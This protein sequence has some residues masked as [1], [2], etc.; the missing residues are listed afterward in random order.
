M[1][2]AIKAAVKDIADV[3]AQGVFIHVFITTLICWE[4]SANIFKSSMK[5]FIKSLTR[6][7]KVSRL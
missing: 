2:H 6:N 7:R 5:R 4:T 1:A 3:T